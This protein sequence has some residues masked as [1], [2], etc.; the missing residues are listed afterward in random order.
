M[1]EPIPSEY[2][3][4]W[5]ITDTSQWVNDGLDDLGPAVISLTGGADRLRMH[6]LLA[7]VNC[8]HTKTG[9]SF[10]WEGAWEYHQMSGS[11][12]VNLGTDGRLKGIIRI[13]DGDSSTLIAERTEE[14]EEPVPP[15]RAIGTSG[16]GAGE[17]LHSSRLPVTAVVAN[18]ADPKDAGLN[19]SSLGG[20][21]GAVRRGSR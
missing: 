13:K 17:G 12:R 20:S 16:V 19:K 15:P 2:E 18:V 9:V 10:T 4:W 7:Y 8:R 21:S 1:N 5:R 11:G 6:C 3:G 14:P